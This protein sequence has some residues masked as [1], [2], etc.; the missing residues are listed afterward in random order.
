MS[1]IWHEINNKIFSTASNILG[2]KVQFFQRFYFLRG[3]FFLKSRLRVQVRFLANA[4]H[5]KLTYSLEKI[6]ALT[7][8]Y[9]LF[10]F[11]LTLQSFVFFKQVWVIHQK[12]RDLFVVY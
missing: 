7:F 11:Y 4:L 8:V 6:Q 9:Y 1:F 10:L 12:Y 2:L 5:F 3:L